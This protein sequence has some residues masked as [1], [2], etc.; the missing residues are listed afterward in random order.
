MACRSRLNNYTPVT[1]EGHQNAR[2]PAVPRS[3]CPRFN[4][5]QPGQHPAHLRKG[6]REAVAA[7]RS[8]ARRAAGQTA[9]PPFRA[10]SRH[11]QSHRSGLP[12]HCRKRGCTIRCSASWAR[13]IIRAIT[14]RAVA[15]R[16]T[17]SMRTT[18]RRHNSGWWSKY[19]HQGLSFQ[20]RPDDPEKRDAAIRSS[21]SS[22]ARS[23]RASA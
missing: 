19:G 18:A 23:R 17:S 10:R 13:T 11:A 7:R 3:R 6:R 14:A 16:A 5:G 1:P 20:R 9:P 2:H 8:D 12:R 4:L 22:R 21:I 15:R